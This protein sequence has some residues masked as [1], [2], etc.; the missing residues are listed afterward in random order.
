MYF[1]EG[2]AARFPSG[3][4]GPRRSKY[5]TLL[6]HPAPEQRVP[7]SAGDFLSTIIYSKPVN[8]FCFFFVF[9]FCN[10]F[11]SFSSD[12]PRYPSICSAI[13]FVISVVRWL[14][15]LRL[16][17]AEV[18]DRRLAR[19]VS[20]SPDV[21]LVLSS[22]SRRRRRRRRRHF[23]WAPRARRRS[24]RRVRPDSGPESADSTSLP[25]ILFRERD[26]RAY[27]LLLP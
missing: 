16:I 17:F 20:D 26:A 4:R 14:F 27:G 10:S 22:S 23:R 5:N 19:P 6:P 21:V 11:S 2:V 15:E 24:K 7:I 12:F 13:Y 18:R 1:V 25:G 3:L 8:I 9:F